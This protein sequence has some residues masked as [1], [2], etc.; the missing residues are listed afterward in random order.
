MI[1]INRRI[2]RNVSRDYKNLSWILKKILINKFLNGKE[3]LVEITYG[4]SKKWL[5]KIKKLKDER[6][7]VLSKNL[8][9]QNIDISW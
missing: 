4:L 9:S 5:R 8:Q 3:V 1:S 7:S 2:L 6:K